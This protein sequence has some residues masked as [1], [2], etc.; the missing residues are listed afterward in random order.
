MQKPR[1]RTSDKA[2]WVFIHTR[3]RPS[4]TR[5]TINRRTAYRCGY[6]TAAGN[7]LGIQNPEND[8]RLPMP[9]EGETVARYVS[10]VVN[11]LRQGRNG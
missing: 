2:A 3:L 8:K 6:L 5:P 4:A 7:R 1:F 10:R 9:Y 11:A